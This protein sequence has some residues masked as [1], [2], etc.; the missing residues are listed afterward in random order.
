[1]R[2]FQLLL[3]QII[4]LHTILFLLYVGIFGGLILYSNFFDIPGI[5]RRILLGLFFL[6]LLFGFGLAWMYTDHYENRRTGDA[7]RF[8]DDAVLLHGSLDD[9][10][11][12]YAKLMTG[13]S[14]Q[15]DSVAMSYYVRM[16]HFEREFYTGF[17]NDN[18]TIIRANALVMLFSRGYY[19]VHTAFW[20]FFAMVGLTAILK[21]L[22]QFFP[23]K[24]VQML[25]AVFLLPT[26]LFWASGVLKEPILLLGL[27]L[28]LLGFIRLIVNDY[29]KRDL[30]SMVF[31]FLIL[32]FTKG[33]VLQCM[34]PAI[35]GL[36]LVRVFPKQKF[37]AMFSIPHIGAIIL[38]FIGP[39]IS[40]GLKVAELMS[41]KQ[42]AFYNIS[43]ESGAGS[44]IEIPP[45]E[46]SWDVILNAPTALKNT[47]LRPWPWE[48]SKLL[49]I[50]A[51]LENFI[52][53]LALFLMLWNFR[54]PSGMGLPIIA[55]SLSFIMTLGI[56]S[57]EVVPVLGALVRYK[58]PALIFL[59]VLI[60][61]LTND[62]KLTRRI[63]ILKRLFN[64]L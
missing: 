17:L 55:F 9:G 6:K 14:L 41:L 16:T 43:N 62:A 33:Y 38:I 37:W 1:M 32:L 10:I 49:Y 12:T 53:M 11:G 57:G 36:L 47:Y 21:L 59:F 29:R 3:R 34:A 30:I 63:P 28:F 25:F 18:A 2:F 15:E 64:L 50:P 39:Y 60:F 45:I 54:K 26:V 19:H 27:G 8:Y 13:I 7:F 48:W 52:L 23:T 51:G 24:K 20:C 31:G 35:T 42:T 58:L 5:S 61:A 56:I 4:Q 40:D 22:V 46:S 44:T